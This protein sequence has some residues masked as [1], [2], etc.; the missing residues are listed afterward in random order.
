MTHLS[1]RFFLKA[2]GMTLISL[3]A[4]SMGFEPH[5]LR[6]TALAASGAKAFR[7]PKVLVTVF[8][9]GAMDGLMAVPPLDEKRMKA[10]RPRL[11]MG[12]AR[13]EGE[14]RLLDLG[15]GF[16]LHPAFKPLQ[17]FF[18]D[19][20]LGIVHAVGS[21]DPTRSHFDA[22]DF[23]ETGTPG[24]KGTSSGW[25]NRVSGLLGHEATPFRSVSLTTAMPKSFYG[26]ASAL[27]VSDLRH[28]KVQMPGA[29]SA[30]VA[31]GGGF[32]AL[33]D[34]TSQDLL[35]DTGGETFEAVKMLKEARL[36]SYR[37]SSQARYP[38]SPLGNSLQQIAFLIKSN[39]GLEVAFAESGGW[40]THVGQGTAQGTFARRAGDL[41]QSIAAF[42][43]DLGAYRD[44]VILMTMTEFGRTVRENGSGGTDHGH[45]SCLFLLGGDVQGGQVHGRLPPLTEGQL[46][47]G[48]DLPVTTDFRS[49]FFEVASNH[50]GITDAESVFP[51]WVQKNL[52]VFKT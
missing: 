20:D 18:K 39:L 36:S 24:R 41:A 29:E 5:F 11:F 7:R 49:V 22:Q 47:E 6:R 2:G 43:E 52:G 33:Y 51:G 25:L 19:G 3:G 23:M 45:G 14:D 42:W 4:G 13:S 15:N 8:Q 44:D 9:R 35:K 1:R 28:F 12:A 21:H 34:Q 16:G 30:A 31:A 10:Y 17:P 37:P 46:F 40:D 48:R 26:D 27:A 50:L 38:R 32:E